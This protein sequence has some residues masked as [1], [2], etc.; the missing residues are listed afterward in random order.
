MFGVKQIMKRVESVGNVS[1]EAAGILSKACELFIMDISHRSWIFTEE[2]SRKK[3]TPKDIQ[4]ASDPIDYFD[5]FKDIR[6][7][8]QDKENKN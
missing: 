2:D 5:F 1:A 6:E 4:K 8:Y 7:E 3:L